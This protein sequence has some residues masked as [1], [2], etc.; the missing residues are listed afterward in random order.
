MSHEKVLKEVNTVTDSG[1]KP[2]KSVTSMSS[3][4]HDLNSTRGKP[5]LPPMI[6]ET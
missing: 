2:P 5:L 4:H 1:S 3:H 6:I